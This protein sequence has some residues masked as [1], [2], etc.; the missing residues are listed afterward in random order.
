MPWRPSDREPLSLQ[1]ADRAL[2]ARQSPIGKASD[3][4]PREVCCALSHAAPGH[5]HRT[6]GVGPPVPPNGGHLGRCSGDS[7]QVHAPP[8][9]ERNA[10]DHVPAT[11]AKPN[12]S[13]LRSEQKVLLA[14]PPSQTIVAPCQDQ[15]KC[16][17]VKVFS[18]KVLW[19]GFLTEWETSRTFRVAQN[20]PGR[21]FD[22]VRGRA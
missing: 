11:G 14:A 7:P 4:G 21:Y 5:K 12:P 18:S 13:R 15:C 19:A 22:D 20:K 16:S 9:P 17:F 2:N 3:H 6:P 10:W 8:K 1:L